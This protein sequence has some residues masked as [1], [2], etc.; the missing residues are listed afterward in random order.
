MWFSR[1]RLWISS[2]WDLK[3]RPDP[4]LSP[5]FQL[6]TYKKTIAFFPLLTKIPFCKRNFT[7]FGLIMV[8]I[9]IRLGKFLIRTKINEINAGT[10][11]WRRCLRCIYSCNSSQWPPH[12]ADH[13]DD[14]GVELKGNFSSRIWA[15]FF[16][17]CETRFNAK[18][19]LV[20]IRNINLSLP[21]PDNKGYFKNG[22]I[23]GN[24]LRTMCIKPISA[25]VCLHARISLFEKI[26][27]ITLIKW[28]AKWPRN[29]SG[30]KVH[31]ETL[32]S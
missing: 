9:R 27:P 1:P 11:Q 28:P 19:W 10:W 8:E 12:P 22:Q 13:H 3:R 32:P 7:L 18:N 17:T 25:S 6:D 29:R 5:Y 4:T 2:I 21:I 24:K 14:L 30:P 31:N 23:F 20:N 26:R 15:N 16:R